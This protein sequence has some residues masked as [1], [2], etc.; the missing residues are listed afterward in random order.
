MLKPIIEDMAWCWWTR[1]RAVQIGGT[2]YFGALD[3]KG[4]MIAATYELDTGRAR[5][6]PLAAFEDDDHNNPALVVATGRPLVAFYSRHDADDA[7][8]YRRSLR[9]LD[10][11]DWEP[12]RVLSF[13]GLTTYAEV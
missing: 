13:G 6:T 8:R 1:P 10:I 9:P 7:L 4:Q 12:E 5:K 2:I 11:N 3:S